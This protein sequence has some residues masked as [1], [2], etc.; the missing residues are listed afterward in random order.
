MG[1]YTPHRP[2]IL[3]AEWIPIKDQPYT[4]AK[5]RELGYTFDIANSVAV[6]SGAIHGVMPLSATQVRALGVAVYPADKLYAPSGPVEQVLIPAADGLLVGTAAL[7]GSATSIADAL[8]Y[9]GDFRGVDIPADAASAGV[10]AV[11]VYF[12]LNSYPQLSGKRILNVEVIQSTSVSSVAP[13][14]TTVNSFLGFDKSFDN[15]FLPGVN[16]RTGVG[17]GLTVVGATLPTDNGDANLTVRSVAVGELNQSVITTIGNKNLLFPWIYTTLQLFDPATANPSQLSITFDNAIMPAEVTT[18]TVRIHYA[19]LRITYCDETRLAVGAVLGND[20]E[21]M[22]TLLIRDITTLAAGSTTLPAGSYA[23][24]VGEYIR[25]DNAGSLLGVPFTSKAVR[26]LTELPSHRGVDLVKP[27]TVGA[28]LVTRATMQLPQVEI[29]TSAGVVT[30]C[31]VYGAQLAAPVYDTVTAT[32][33]IDR[34]DAPSA[35]TFYPLARFFARRF[36][37]TNVPLT[38]TGTSQSPSPAASITPEDFDA[39]PELVDGWRQIDLEFT[40]PTPSFVGTSGVVNWQW[41]ATGLTSPNRWE[42]LAMDAPAPTGSPLNLDAATYRSPGGSSANLTWRGVSDTS[43]DAV[44]IFSQSPPTVTGLA[45]SVQTQQLEVVDPACV[46][47]GARCLPSGLYYHHISW[48][49]R[50][51]YDSFTRTNVDSWSNADT[52]Q[53]WTTVT[54]ASDLDVN[55]THGILTLPSATYTAGATLST[56]SIADLDL[57]IEDVFMSS[58]PTTGQVVWSTAARI[59]GGGS[60][61][62]NARVFLNSAGTVTVNLRQVVGG[63]D[64]AITGFPT[65]PGTTTIPFN[66][67][68]RVNGSEARFRVWRNNVAEPV[69]WNVELTGLT[70]LAAGAVDVRTALSAFGGAALPYTVS[71]GSY[72][73]V[74]TDVVGVELQRQDD[75][76]VDWRTIM[77]SSVP[78]GSFDDYEARVDVSTRYRIRSYNALDFTGTWSSEVTSTL[79]APGVVVTDDGAGTLIFTSNECPDGSRN[80]AYAMGWEGTPTEDFSFAEGGAV[81]Y[82]PM[83]RRDYPVAFHGTEREGEQFSRTLLVQAAALPAPSLGNFRSLRDLAWAG[84]SYVCVRDELGNRWFA[85][86]RVP[87]GVVRRNRQLYLARLDI[88]EV[89]MIPTSV[90]PG[91]DACF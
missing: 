17:G 26:Q 45:V 23:V 63:V 54:A 19:A 11:D 85:N 61:Q 56:V 83:Y 31:H 39:L 90:D 38:L 43:T 22:T 42:V 55:G 1:D 78:A 81:Q 34:V 15:A 64:T 7:A 50:G 41:S 46:V 29:F 68:L 57:V 44:L 76:D 28:E 21:E 87:A 53:A 75:V 62:I 9:P 5:D 3:G 77:R 88:V 66:A 79:T 86:V 67:R 59:T 73:A 65:A 37:Q 25:H 30:G 82:H 13:A 36:G 24:T 84:L 14:G 4:L 89:S 18:F 48:I 8:A 40:S 52:G 33:E 35:A 27:S 60:N 16:I 58:M 20:T 49:A 74:A 10:N 72:R 80:L 91:S 32:Q 71:I 51:V 69:G 70:H 6:V 2:V 12:N 47:D